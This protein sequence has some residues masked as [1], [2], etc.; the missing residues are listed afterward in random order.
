MIIAYIYLVLPMCQLVFCFTRLLILTITLYLLLP[1]EGTMSITVTAQRLPALWPGER[2]HRLGA[3]L[4]WFEF[5]LFLCAA[6]SS[7]VK[8]DNNYKVLRTEPAVCK[9]R[10]GVSICRGLSVCMG[11]CCS[12]GGDSDCTETNSLAF[13]GQSG[14]ISVWSNQE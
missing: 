9:D 4:P 8:W 6:I 14:N 3:S 11:V 13:R 2:E 1:L 10:L 12:G 5:W 7:P